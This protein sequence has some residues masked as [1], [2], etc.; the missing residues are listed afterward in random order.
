MVKSLPIIP[1]AGADGANLRVVQH[2]GL[3]DGAS[4]VVQ[5]PG[6]YRGRNPKFDEGLDELG[7][8]AKN[9][10]AFGVPETHFA[11]VENLS[12]VHPDLEALQP[13]GGEGAVDDG[14]NFR[15]MAAI[16]RESFSL[17]AYTPLD[18]PLIEASEILLA[19]GGG[20][21]EKQI[22]RFTKGDSSS[23]RASPNRPGP[24]RVS[25]ARRWPHWWRQ[26]QNADRTGG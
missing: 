18:T 1:A 4:V 2:G 9:L 13:Q 25:A 20:E 17:Y 19:K 16:I 5:A 14:G 3:V 24:D 10:A 11:L 22:Y 15:V 23:L 6:G 26:G 12:V 7:T 8:V 21:T